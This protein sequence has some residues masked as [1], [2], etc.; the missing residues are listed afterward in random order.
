M[1]QNRIIGGFEMAIKVL[2]PCLDDKGNAA[3]LA[4]GM[5]EVSVSG[6]A[7]GELFWLMAEEEQ[8]NFFASLYEIS[9]SEERN[10]NTQMNAMFACLT[11]DVRRFIG[12]LVVRAAG[13]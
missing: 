12:D 1:L 8:A 6:K 9:I 10:F 5:F 11:D 3:L 2:A 4:E 13:A 7:L